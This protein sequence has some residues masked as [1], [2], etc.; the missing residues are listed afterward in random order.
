MA[1]QGDL[2]SRI[3]GSLQWKGD[4]GLNNAGVPKMLRSKALK[5]DAFAQPT[6]V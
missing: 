4:E 5:I 1:I 2:M 6:V 3:L